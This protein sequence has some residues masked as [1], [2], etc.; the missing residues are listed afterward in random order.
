MFHTHKQ[1]IK[2]YNIFWSGN[3]RGKEQLKLRFKR[4]GNTEIDLKKVIEYR[5]VQFI[6]LRSV[7]LVNTGMKPRVQQ[8]DME[9]LE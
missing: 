5:H 4:E 2:V 3:P 6:W 7:A 9:F 8:S 1:P